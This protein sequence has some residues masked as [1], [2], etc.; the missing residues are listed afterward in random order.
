MAGYDFPRQFW[1]TPVAIIPLLA[2]LLYQAVD[3]SWYALLRRS[4]YFVHSIMHR[5]PALKL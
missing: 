3:S 4:N 5:S 1:Y 2:V